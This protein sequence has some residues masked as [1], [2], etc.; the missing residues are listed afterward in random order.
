MKFTEV[1]IRRP[2]FACVL[3]LILIVVGV[4]AYQTL[5]IRY[6]PQIPRPV[7]TVHVS[8]P[9]ASADLMESSVTNIIEGAISDV[10]N[11]KYMTSSSRSGSASINLYFSINGDFDQEVNTVR[12]KVAGV[13]N[14]LPSAI[15]SVSVTVGG[16]ERPVLNLGF[17][18]KNMSQQAMRNYIIQFIQPQLNNVPGVG[19]V[20]TYGSSGY[21]MRIWLKPE[22]MAALNITADDIVS[23]LNANNVDFPAGVV[24]DPER[25]FS[26]VSDI[27][28]KT[29]KQFGDI[30][31]KSVGGKPIYLKNIADVKWGPS[32]LQESPML[33][34]GKPGIDVEVRPRFG[35]NPIDVASAVRD[36][37]AKIK[38]HLP[39]NINVAVTYDQ[40][41]FLQSSIEETAMS[42]FYA[43]IL[44]ILVVVGF[45]GSFRA[46]MVP[47]I[48]I[49]LCLIDGFGVMRLFG[50]SINIMTLLALV[51]AI[52][53]VVDDAIVMLE[54]IHRHIEE[55]LDRVA[56]AIKGSREI[57]FAVIAMT[58]TLAAVY[59]PIGFASGVSAAV[60]RE[61]AFTL[62]GT[63]IISGFVAITLSPMMC[64]KILVS[65]V[66]ENKFQKRLNEI[67]ESISTR[68][69]VILRFMLCNRLWVIAVLVIIA[70]LGYFLYQVMPAEFVP[71]EDIGYF[72][73]KVIP[74]SGASIQ[75]VNRQM[76]KLDKLYK[77]EASIA[78]YASFVLQNG[79]T[80]FVTL[81]DWD[82]RSETLA[83]I[84][85]K[86]KADMAIIPG[87]TAYPMVPS[88]VD[89]GDTDNNDLTLEVMTR[90]SYK[91]LNKTMQKLKIAI[92]K[93]PG[94]TDVA[95]NL[96]FNS[97]VYKV[98]LRREMIGSL[99]VNP[100][101]VADAMSILLGG[102]HV[103]DVM[104]GNQSYPVKVQ[105][106]KSDL[107]NFQGFGKLYLTTQ[108]SGQVV[109]LVNLVS[110]TPTIGQTTLT[111]Y[112]RMRS[113]TIT[114]QLKP[115]YSEKNLVDFLN[116][117]VPNYINQQESYA[118]SGKIRQ[119]LSSQGD[120]ASMFVLSLIFIYLILAATFESFI[121]PFVILLAVPL[122]FVGALAVLWVTGGSINL[123]TNIG[124]ITLVGLIAKHGIL[125]TQFANDLRK[126]G[127]AVIDA[128]VEA[129]A[130]RLRPIF[131][132][133]AAMILGS[134]PL[135]LA[136][137]PGTISHN[138]IG[139]VIVGGLFFG[140]FFSLVVV[141]IAYVYLSALKMNNGK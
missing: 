135:A 78:Y 110:I 107:K 47:I 23:A 114:G 65:N 95:D 6:F 26:V 106:Q 136:S 40:S 57:A 22:R 16:V 53:L 24:L 80:S 122:S 112:N 92:A 14:K 66:K 103:T 25:T 5:E 94:L 33:I 2:V 51:L 84:L 69:K 1:C 34:N 130:V 89:L 3:N 119:F 97:Q 109:P 83:Q 81:K 72:E 113:G 46:S 27:Q 128:V 39:T 59:A 35:E 82:K 86:L 133:T 141:P 138:Q 13:K 67:F 108:N 64:S 9:G 17:T 74:P 121:D 96:R 43:V 8:Y 75:Y 11:V 36:E 125:I 102:K 50:F 77:N 49:P 52:G 87:V 126:E 118:F 56:A 115:G 19:A 98:N 132:T 99:G 134:I 70:I 88:P 48:T 91:D 55:G 101:D 111:H 29:P 7:A 28:L 37:L 30:I 31:I 105:V 58:I 41:T 117:T 140:T 73:T 127:M 10:P 42:I 76:M 45:L 63:V 60:F 12:D 38:K 4:V 124:M 137:G 93:Y 123:F 139:W 61:F 116:K 131:M 15:D 44:V 129:A 62:A 120:M 18:S 90:G 32:A 104:L 71:Q 54:N 85:A 21:S 79:P 20:W 68:Y 100:Q